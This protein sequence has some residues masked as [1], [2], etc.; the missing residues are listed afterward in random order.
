M[1]ESGD[2]DALLPTCPKMKE[3]PK[4][5]R[6]HRGGLRHKGPAWA[7]RGPAINDGI[8]SRCN[9]DNSSSTDGATPRA[10]WAEGAKGEWEAQFLETDR[11]NITFLVLYL[12]P[13]TLHLTLFLFTIL[14]SA[15]ARSRPRAEWTGLTSLRLGLIS[16]RFWPFILW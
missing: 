14:H 3:K 4:Q 9:N 2:S 1:A 5:R 8:W 16:G 15:R 13:L 10:A 7:Q 12:L 11:E 6:K